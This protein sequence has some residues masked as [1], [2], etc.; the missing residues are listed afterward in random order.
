[1][2]PTQEVV[3]DTAGLNTAARKPPAST[4]GT[5][6]SMQS[7]RRTDTKPEIALRSELHRRGLRFRKDMLIHF[8]SLSARPDVVFTKAKVAVFYDGC[9][10]HGCSEHGMRP[11]RNAAFWNQKIDGT[12]ERDRRITAALTDAG[13]TV[14]RAWEHEPIT[15]AAERIERAIR[16]THR[17]HLS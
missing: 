17:L 5:Q 16:R 9:W 3:V 11:K 10:W 8:D 2:S 13:W 15:E 4:P 14:I 1:M 12:I 6:K 7:N